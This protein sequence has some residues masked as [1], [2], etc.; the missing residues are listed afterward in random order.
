M[1]KVKFDVQGMTCSSCSAHVERAV[2]KLDGVSEVTVNLLSNNMIVDYDD[3]KLNNDYIIKSV[4]DAGYGASLSD[5]NINNERNINT[6]TNNTKNNNYKDNRNMRNK[7]FEDNIKSMKRRLIASICFLI[8]LMY[9][10]MHTMLNNLFNIPVPKLVAELFDGT[11]NALTFGF[12]QFLLVLPIVYINRNYFITGFKRLAKRTPTMESL[13]AMGSSAAIL[14]GLY[15]L[16]MISYGLGHND[17]DIVQK[18]S[19]D[20]YFESAGT[21]LT[22]I[23]FGKFLETKSKGKTSAAIEKLI[24]LSPKTAIVLRNNKE[25][26]IPT[27]EILKDDI[28]II[29]PGSSIPVDGIIIEGNSSVDQSTI[30]GESIPVDKST[31]DTVVS[32]TINKSGYFKMRATKVGEDSTLAQIIK[33][34]EN[35]GNTKAP[36]AKIADKVSG[37]F[38]P[39]VILIAIITTVFWIIRGQSFEFALS[40]GISV[41]VISCP[42][43]LGL[44]TP[45]AIMVGMGKGATQGILIKSAEHLEA[46][47]SID[48]VVLDKTGTITVGKPKVIDILSCENV[49]EI[50]LL[51][52]AASI[53]SKSEHPLGEAIVAKAK[54]EQLNLYDTKEFI[55]TPGRG[56]EAV[57]KEKTYLG[58]NLAFLIEKNIIKPNESNKTQANKNEINKNETNINEYII[59]KAKEYANQ[60]KTVLYFAENKKLIGIISI[61][62]TIK[63]TSYDAIQTLKNKKI[64]VVM[65]TGDNLAVATTIG[66]ELGIEKIISEVL[67]QDKEK[68]VEKLQKQGKKVAFVG[69][70][71]NDSPALVRA[72]VGIAIGSGTD[73]AIE[74][75]DVVLKNDNLLSVDT[76]IELSKAVMRNIKI[77][78]FWA[79]FYNC[80]GIPVAAGVFYLSHGLKLNPMLGAAAMSLSSVCVVTNALTLNF[81]KNKK[82][83]ITNQ[84]N[85][86]ETDKNVGSNDQ[87][88]AESNEGGNNMEKIIKEVIIEGMQ[89][90]HCKMTV[91]KVL[92]ALNDVIKV[93][94][95]LENKSAIV[96]SKNEIDD[97]KIKEVI[98][99]AGFEVKEIK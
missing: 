13:I 51:K 52:I 37:V 54:E 77:N 85:K 61:A 2:K 93:E 70:G 79:F 68:E 10:A 27:E 15:A 1:V 6:D 50:E 22:L 91:E 28:V 94:V 69:D 20:L 19:A 31:N 73:I 17:L 78:L 9:V 74:S 48:T 53:E 62:D 45:V 60:G 71:I 29:K 64:D 58:G 5:E 95:N 66:N 80:I 12:T 42:C 44:A 41:L 46:L 67:P 11:Q 72:D 98:E 34:V 86:I 43:A 47:H 23:T 89:C 75:A 88:V 87:L 21:I 35:A 49:S 57:I 25:Q 32:G 30:T 59:E 38:V 84:N 55:Y 8:P 83:C 92:T 33:L 18:F 14:Y 39:T 24:N 7:K 65:L 97:A 63:K 16:Y 3:N 82:Q 96:E 26:E 76:A 36:I 40:M 90:N 56:V 81:F 4:V 99:E